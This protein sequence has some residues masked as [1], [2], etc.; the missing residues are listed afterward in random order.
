MHTRISQLLLSAI[1]LL[2]LF[3][4][5]C[6][7]LASRQF[8]S[9]SERPSQ[10]QKFFDELD[11]TVA[12]AGARDASG[13]TVEGFPYLRAN[14][15]LA[16]FKD[17]LSAEDQKQEWVYRMQQMDLESRR[18]EINNLSRS[19]IQALSS[20]LD[21]SFDR[22]TLFSRVAFYSHQL[23]AHD[24]RQP[25]FYI[26]LQKAVEIPDEYFT[27]M[28]VIGIYPITSLPVAAVTHKVF[29]EITEWHQTPL[30]E[31]ETVGTVK[32]YGP[33]QHLKYSPKKIRTMLLASGSNPLRI[34]DLSESERRALLLM[35]APVF[36]QDTVADYDKIGEMIW[37]NKQ[38]VVNP[39]IPAVYYYFSHARFKGMPV[40]QLNY[41]IWFS[42]RKGPES[43]WIERGRLDGLAVRISLDPEGRPF[44]VDIMNNCGCY[45]FF[46]PAEDRVERILPLDYA[47]DAF[48]PRWLPASFPQNRLGVHI[49]SGW[50]QVNHIGTMDL[51]PDYVSYRL[52]PYEELESLPRDG[53]QFESI[54]NSNG[55]VKY[56][57]R[58]EPLIFFPMG[59]PDIGSMRQRGHHAVKF[60][61]REHFDDPDIFD[62]NFEFR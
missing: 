39:S 26:T 41:V 62:R 25:D 2:L 47:I 51:P 56:T 54:F 57:P 30:H 3:S 11:H 36:A 31:L 12:D 50:H 6:A 29:E 4:Q 28:R 52:V 53:Q 38:P 20:R 40:I 32:Y 46:V 14:R 15:F 9:N 18:K 35:F 7:N 22:D 44:M 55:I 10:Y 61:G 8:V 48:V 23:L 33:H 16:S 19:L 43:P 59:I 37:E 24:Q 5:G 27:T 45:H 42:A 34:P 13:F 60:V 1:L 17:E 49:K 21:E 58:I